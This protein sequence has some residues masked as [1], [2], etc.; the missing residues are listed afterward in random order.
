MKIEQRKNPQ[1]EI[2]GTGNYIIEV[3]NKSGNRRLV[4][5]RDWLTWGIQDTEDDD[6]I[7]SITYIDRFSIC[8]VSL[9]NGRLKFIKPWPKG[10]AKEL[11]LEE[12]I[13]GG[14][15]Y[16]YIGWML[17]GEQIVRLESPRAFASSNNSRLCFISELENHTF[18]HIDSVVF[19]KVLESDNA[20]S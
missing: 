18:K 10:G 6:A 12:A 11:F 20:S 1:G 5:M 3:F 9:I 7:G 17:T 13:G 8:K 14:L 2:W 19:E 15:G 16:R 4:L